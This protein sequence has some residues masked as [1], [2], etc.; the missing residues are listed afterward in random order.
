M[1]SPRAEGI[2]PWPPGPLSVMRSEFASDIAMPE[3]RA[4]KPEGTRDVTWNPTRRAPSMAERAPRSSIAC[5]PHSASSAG[6]KR[7]M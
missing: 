4:T 5:A 6:W 1:T 3:R 2:A 7:K